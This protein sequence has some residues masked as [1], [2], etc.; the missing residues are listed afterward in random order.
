M[1]WRLSS[2]IVWRQRRAELKSEAVSQS[3]NR[4]INTEGG[5]GAERQP[6]ESNPNE[7]TVMIY[8]SDS[9]LEDTVSLQLYHRQI[10]YSERTKG[11][12]VTFSR[13]QCPMRP[14]GLQHASVDTKT[15]NK[16]M[17]D[18]SVDNFFFFHCYLTIRWRSTRIKTL[19]ASIK[20]NIF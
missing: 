15:N 11:L 5:G 12:C 2:S 16:S 3:H 1:E 19:S 17:S 9:T 4:N 8:A 7:W 6:R 10:H 18:Y 13:I 20:Y 14:L